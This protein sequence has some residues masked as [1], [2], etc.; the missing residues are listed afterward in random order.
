MKTISKPLKQNCPGE[1]LGI[2]GIWGFP[3]E[4]KEDMVA[5]RSE[6]QKKASF[7]SR[8]TVGFVKGFNL[9]GYVG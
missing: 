2:F 7:R 8:S 1:L 4:D 5:E 6:M 3:F 9:K